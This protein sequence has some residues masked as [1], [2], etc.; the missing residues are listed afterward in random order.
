MNNRHG[1]SATIWS[2]TL[3]QALALPNGAGCLCDEEVSQAQKFRQMGDKKRFLAGRILL[4]HA[5]SDAVDGEIGIGKWRYRNGPN[6][7]PAMAPDFPK[8]EFNLSHSKNCVV[9][10]LSKDGQIGVDIEIAAPDEGTQIVD[11]VLSERERKILHR[12][13]DD[14]KGAA[15]I[16]LWTLK[17]ACAKALG[18]GVMLDFRNV[19]TALEPPRIINS[20]HL[21]GGN[22][23]FAIESRKILIDQIPYFICAVKITETAEKKSFC[24]KT[25]TSI[26]TAQLSDTTGVC[27]N[28]LTGWQ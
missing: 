12:L 24:Y 28:Q 6:G 11:D 8:L 23:E 20:R 16:Q 9:V 21:P 15:F 22:K 10:A 19:D 13:P 2:A 4:R 26:R 14:Q 1:Y 18:L 17:E 3:D 25:L 5:L 7:K 27:E